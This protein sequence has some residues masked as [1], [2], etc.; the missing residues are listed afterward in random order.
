[1]LALQRQGFLDFVSLG[2]RSPP[3]PYKLQGKPEIEERLQEPDA[4]QQE[5]WLA[6]P[7]AKENASRQLSSWKTGATDLAYKP[8][9]PPPMEVPASAVKK[10]DEL[11]ASLSQVVVN[12][13]PLRENKLG[14]LQKL[15]PREQLKQRH[16]NS[17]VPSEE[18][19][20]SNPA[21]RR[22]WVGL[23]YWKSEPVL[24]RANV[25]SKPKK[26]ITMSYP[27]IARIARGQRATTEKGD[28]LEGLKNPGE[29]IIVSTDR[30]IME[31]RECVRRKIGGL[32]LCRVS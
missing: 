32:A 9:P 19:V 2:G 8:S 18:R 7:E 27:V 29:C 5:P 14:N 26:S 15:A 30:G 10:I 3:L 17:G 24:S 11:A 25:I 4:I 21:H 20:P 23:K 13:N 31:A 6:F 16:I 22:I 28:I 1:M 12:D